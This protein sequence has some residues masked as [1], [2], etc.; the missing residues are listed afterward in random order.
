MS[1]SVDGSSTGRAHDVLLLDFGG[2]CLLNPVELHHVVEAHFGLERGTFGW[3]GPLDVE[4]DELYARSLA[5]DGFSER[6]YWNARAAEVG[7]TAGVVLDL[8]E[9]MH[10][11][12]ALTASGDALIRPAAVEV[13]GRARDAGIGVAVLTNDL[14]AFHD[15]E[16][17]AQIDFLQRLD[18]LVD[19]SHLGFLKPDP[20]A[21]ELAL[22]T[23]RSTQPELRAD[24]VLFVDDQPRNVD[25]ATTAGMEGM[26]FDIAAADRS[27]AQVGERLGV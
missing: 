6:D 3:F 21:Y 7:R 16:W 26:F 12:Y 11:A 4:G 5:D 15:D 8:T 13:C 19:C 18:H 25:G 24:R 20:R 23:L 14:H 22:D 27:W 17:V 2:V 1:T 9:Y 10:I